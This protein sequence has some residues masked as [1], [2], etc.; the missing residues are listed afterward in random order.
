MPEIHPPLDPGK[1]V[2]KFSDLLF[3]FA[4]LRVND[5]E[6]AKDLVQDTFLAALKNV[7]GYRG[8]L[9]EKNWLMM[10]LKNKII[11]QY[12]KHATSK[13]V[14]NESEPEQTDIFFDE[15]DH[16][17]VKTAPQTWTTAPEHEFEQ[18]E[19]SE[20]LQKC[21]SK[22]SQIMQTVFSMKYLDEEDSDVICKELTITSSNYWVLIHRSKL[23]VRACIEK[24]WFVK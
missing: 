6:L 24:N 3:R 16:W 5:R 22:L 12:R 13:E 2:E 14:L 9:S 21:V 7:S 15:K 18:G 8:E 23:Q 19:F 17:K 11:D 20:I 10:I 1:W 4:I